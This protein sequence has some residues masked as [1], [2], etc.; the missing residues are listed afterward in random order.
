LNVCADVC[1]AASVNYTFRQLR[2]YLFIT[3]QSE[4]R[5]LRLF[6]IFQCRFGDPFNVANKIESDTADAQSSR[7]RRVIVKSKCCE[8]RKV[9]RLSVRDLYRCE[10]V[11]AFLKSRPLTNACLI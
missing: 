8:S 1:A 10:R 11:V 6:I 2:L 4:P 9:L 5:P 7:H 3:E